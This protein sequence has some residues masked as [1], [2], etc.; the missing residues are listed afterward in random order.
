MN[1]L[2]EINEL[3]YKQIRK[4]T[5]RKLAQISKEIAFL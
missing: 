5:H 3:L 1:L 4:L 2:Q